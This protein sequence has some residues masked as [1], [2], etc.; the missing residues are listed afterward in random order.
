MQVSLFSS[1][2]IKKFG[3][4]AI[5]LVL[6]ISSLGVIAEACLKPSDSQPKENS[7]EYFKADC[8][9]W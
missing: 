2:L 1:A 3:C 9:K 4:K 6:L 7:T 5:S 8:I